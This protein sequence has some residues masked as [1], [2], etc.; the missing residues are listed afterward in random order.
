M[1]V[2]QTP[3]CVIIRTKKLF[4]IRGSEIVRNSRFY[5]FL[6]SGSLGFFPMRPPCNTADRKKTP[7]LIVQSLRAKPNWPNNRHDRRNPSCNGKV[8][9]HI[10]LSWL[11]RPFAKATFTCS[12]F[13][14]VLTYPSHPQ[15]LKNHAP[16][17]PICRPGYQ[18]SRAQPTRGSQHDAY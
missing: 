14:T 18:R 8:F 5:L 4:S 12:R 1:S 11:L 7:S 17:Q 10:S 16:I 6:E 13:L 9:H 2:S 15:R 3:E